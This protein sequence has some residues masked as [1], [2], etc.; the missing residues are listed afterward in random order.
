MSDIQTISQGNYILSNMAAQKLY[1]QS[2]LTTGVSGT[3]AYI[4][5]EPS[6][7]YN[8]TVLW[9]GSA[10]AGLFPITLSEPT[11][12]FEEIKFVWTPRYQGDYGCP[13][14]VEVQNTNPHNGIIK[15]TLMHA[16]WNA[17]GPWLGAWYL[18]PTDNY[19]KIASEKN[20]FCNMIQSQNEMTDGLNCFMWK[21][22]GIN[23]KE[24]V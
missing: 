14:V 11:T 1:A 8:E 12:A 23:R 2:P 19:T 16:Y 21:V 22:V 15:Y 10:N 13:T 7:Q 17:N 24:N 18:A 9:E 3:S 6:A 20:A 5:I 4:G